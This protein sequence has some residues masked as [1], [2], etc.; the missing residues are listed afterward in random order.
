M[1]TNLFGATSLT[2]GGAGSLDSIKTAQIQDADVCFVTMNSGEEFYVYTF[3]SGNVAAESSP[4]VIYPDDASGTE[5]WLICDMTMGIGTIRGTLGV[6]GTSAFTGN[7]TMAG[8]LNI[9]ATTAIAGCL[10]ED[11]MGSNSATNVATQ[12]S[13][14]AYVDT[15]VSGV[16]VD[17]DLLAGFL[18]RPRFSYNSTT[19]IYINSGRYHLLGTAQGEN[20]YKWDSQLTYTFTGLTASAWQYLYID[21]SALADSTTALTA[22]E[23]TNSTT[24]PTWDASECGWYNGADRCIC[25]FLTNSSS[26]ILSFYHDGGRYMGFGNQVTNVSAGDPDTT[27]TDATLSMPTFA[28]RAQITIRNNR[29]VNDEIWI[30][31]RTNGQVGTTGHLAT[32]DTANGGVKNSTNTIIVTTDANQKIEYKFSASSDNDAYIY[33]DGY[34]LPR[35]M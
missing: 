34:Y 18:S 29:P 33:T 22:S 16:A 28:T 17:V 19:A 23:F 25:A 20:I 31:W 12:Q 4:D 27:W 11:A 7:V 32:G 5:A 24:P 30:L 13:I 21:D 9:G 10:D 2:G 8:T 3:D 35:G 1:A 14:K 6:T 15:A 26:Q